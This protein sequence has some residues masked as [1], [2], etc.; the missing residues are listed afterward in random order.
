MMTVLSPVKCPK[1]RDVMRP[2]TFD[3]RPAWFCVR[4]QEPHEDLPRPPQRAAPS[5]DTGDYLPSLFLDH[6]P[7]NAPQPEREYKFAPGRKLSFDLAWPKVKVAVEADGY[8]H[9]TETRFHSDIEKM[10]LATMMGWRVFRCSR[11]ILTEQ[12][13][14]FADVVK[15]AVEDHP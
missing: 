15:N 6:W 8:Y 5:T 1:C 4:C 12:G 14:A 2:V 13:R 7:V 9:K 10:N 3:G 11:R